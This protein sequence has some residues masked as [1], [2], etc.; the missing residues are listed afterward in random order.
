MELDVLVSNHNHPCLSSRRSSFSG[1]G[2]IEHWNALSLNNKDRIVSAYLALQA[3]TRGGW[4]C[5]DEVPVEPMNGKE[6]T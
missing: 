1:A 4:C 2:F 3:I 6:T 5:G